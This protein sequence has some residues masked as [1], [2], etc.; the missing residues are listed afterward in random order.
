LEPWR[1]KEIKL[2]GGR[3]NQVYLRKMDIIARGEKGRAKFGVAI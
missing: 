1:E 3:R 2:Q